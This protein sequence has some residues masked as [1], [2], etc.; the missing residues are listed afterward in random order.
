MKGRPS[1]RAGS[2][3]RNESDELS[4]FANEYHRANMTC[5]AARILILMLGALCSIPAP[6]A[7]DQYSAIRADIEREISAGRATGVAVALTHKGKVVWQEGFGWADK[8]RGRRVTPDTPFSLA[9]V[10]KPF[11]TTAL[12]VLVAAGEVSLDARAND[13]LRAAKIRAGVG[14]PE[15]V[16]VRALASHSSGLPATFQIFPAGGALQ[17]PSMDEVIRNYGVLVSPPNERFEYSNVGLGIVAHIAARRRGLDYGV[18]LRQTVLEPLGLEHSF[19]DTDASRRD[20]MAQRYD[21]EGRPFPFY[22]TSTPGTGELYASAHDV[23]RFAMFHLHDRLADQQQILSDEH[24][25]ELHRPVIRVREDRSY[26]IG[27]M[28]GRAFDG[29]TVV[30]HTGNQAGVVTVM[31]LLP[32]RDIACVVLTNHDDDHDLVER[33]RDA[34]LRTL[35]PGWSWKSLPPPPAQPLPQNYRGTWRGRVHDGESEIPVVL[36]IA[37]QASSLQIGRQA[38]EPISQLG[39]VEGVLVGTTRGELEFPAARAA[40]A[41]GLSLRLQLRGAKLAG[42]IGTEVPI[43][44]AAVPGHLPFWAELA[45]VQP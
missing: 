14:N 18:L 6:C 37:E 19:F 11:T 23:A 36:S 41:E 39:L 32:S 12:M 5:W 7:Q 40:Q 45:R 17:Q 44:R 30:Y 33:T 22:V 16:T 1:Q 3:A 31:M 28:I 24:I 8:A 20:E 25:D 43:A 27:W 21:R 34:A 13:Y 26:G 15:Q 9:S 10:T 29:T 42:E 38:P 4:A 2:C 35:I